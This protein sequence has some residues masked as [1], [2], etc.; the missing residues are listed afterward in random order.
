MKKYAIILSLFAAAFAFADGEIYDEQTISK[1]FSNQSMNRSSWKKCNLSGS[2]FNET[3]LQRAKFDEASF[4]P[5]QFTNCDLTKSSFANTAISQIIFDGCKMDN[6]NFSNVYFAGTRSAAIFRNISSLRNANFTSATF[7]DVY[8]YSNL[9]D[10]SNIDL[11]GAN[12]SNAVLALSSTYAKASVK[13]DNSV[14]AKTNFTGAN[15]AS[16]KTSVNFSNVDLKE[17][18]FT[19]ATMIFDD[20]TYVSQSSVN[21]S[22]SDLNGAKFDN[23]VLG[24]E[25]TAVVFT[26]SNLQNVSFKN[27]TFSNLNNFSYADLRG[28]DLT[29]ATVAGKTLNTIWTDGE[30]KNFSLDDDYL[31]IRA[32]VPTTSGGAMINAKIVDDASISGGAVLALEKGAVLEI[33]SGK[34]L[35]VLDDSEII[36]NVDAASNNTKI[37]L[38]SGSTLAFGEDSKVTINLD[39][40]ISPED[41]Y[42]FSVIEAA[43]DACI[44]G[45]DAISKDNLVL[46][47]NG[48]AYDSDKWGFNFDPTTGALT[49]NVNVPEPATVA[50][51][52]G[53]VAL[54]FAVYR[55]RR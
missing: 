4:G 46:N 47:V 36:F 50:A 52:F 43:A 14:L 35:S 55:R 10:F 23:V 22:N 28:A 1:D 40:V 37:L 45:A 38:N 33:A 20:K 29:G 8:Y 42:T 44:S 41:S 24:G 53:A 34:T 31:S 7:V 54:A 39:G 11:T 19:N 26:K 30:I 16:C 17:A 13:F 27:V 51:I 32:Y 3:K 48:E 5:F 2:T 25:N 21:M 12:F 15:L 6:I 18:D 9:V 49:I